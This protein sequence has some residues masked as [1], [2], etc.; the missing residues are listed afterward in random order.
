MEEL[1]KELEV[2]T[3][4]EKDLVKYK[5]IILTD[6]SFLKVRDALYGNV[7]IVSIDEDRNIIVI[8][9]KTSKISNIAIIAIKVLG[10]EVVMAGYAKEGVI[11]QNTV[12][13]EFSRV[14]KILKGEFKSNKKYRWLGVFVFLLM[15]IIFTIVICAN[16]NKDGKE[17]EKIIN[18]TNEYNTMVD[19][20]NELAKEYNEKYSYGYF[21]ELEIPSKIESIDK[22]NNDEKNAIKQ[23]NKSRK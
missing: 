19:I 12:E 13:K 21:E 4:I 7:E 5:T 22:V 16:R 23:I 14:E 3:N 11:K 15:L 2:N 18:A 6:C 9:S 8:S 17:K 10:N 20:Y 1:I